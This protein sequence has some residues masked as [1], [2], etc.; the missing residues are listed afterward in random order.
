[1]SIGFIVIVG[2]GH[3]ADVGHEATQSEILVFQ[4]SVSV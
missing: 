1:M 4:T 2:E 3:G